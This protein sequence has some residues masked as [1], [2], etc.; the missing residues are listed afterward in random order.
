MTFLEYLPS[1]N[2]SIEQIYG[3]LILFA[4]LFFLRLIGI[5]VFIKIIKSLNFFRMLILRFILNKSIILIYIDANDN[6][7]STSSLCSKL[8]LS[9]RD[10]K[11]K[12]IALKSSEDFLSWS[13]WP[14]LISSIIVILTDVTPFSSNNK[15][16]IR[17]QEKM[18]NYASSGGILVLGHDVLYR[19][20]RNDILEKL[21]GVTL[22]EFHKY[23]KGVKYKKNTSKANKR[24]TNNSELLKHLPDTLLLNDGE[25]VTGEWRPHVEFLYLSDD[26]EQIPLV[27]RQE[28]GNGVVVW[29]NSGDHTEKGPPVSIAQPEKDLILLLNVIFCYA[30]K[31]TQ[32]KQKTTNSKNVTR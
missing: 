21:S 16:R 29:I 7:N 22:T 25:C 6:G 9:L 30:L 4:S 10:K 23:E 14:S 31:S 8:E 32:N 3:E 26:P 2:E 19:R 20:T 17:I 13:M 15:K 27:T 5:D 24:I 28:I 11:V 12:T 1:L 18:S